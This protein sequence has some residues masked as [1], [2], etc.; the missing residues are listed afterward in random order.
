MS[1]LDD[2]PAGLADAAATALGVRG[3]ATVPKSL[4][5]PAVV[6]RTA[7]PF[8]RYQFAMG[9][10]VEAIYRF[11]LLLVASQVADQAAQNRLPEWLSPRG[12]LVAAISRRPGAAV[13]EAGQMGTLEVGS[14]VFSVASLIVEVYG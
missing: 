14:G 4:I 6:V 11:E 10:S 9:N 3:Y 7:E 2:I 13:I 5:A 1:V 12:E 8:I